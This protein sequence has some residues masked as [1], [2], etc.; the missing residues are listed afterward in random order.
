M[1]IVEARRIITGGVDTHLEFHVAAALDP[2]G[3]LLGTQNFRANALGYAALLDWLSDFG[4]VTKVGVEGTGSYGAGLARFLSRHDIA[5]IEVNR[6]DRADQRRSGK[7]D[8]LDA[9]AAARAA[10]SGKAKAISKGKDGHVEA[11]RVL[12][13]AK[14]SAR[15][16]RAKAI[17]Q[18]RNLGITA[19]DELN[20][21][22]QG[23]TVI[24][25]V[26]EGT[27]LRPKRSSDVVTGATKSALSS[28]AHRI[29][30]LD[31][32]L[33]EL[34]AQIAS[35]VTAVAPDLLARFG[36]GPDT[37]AALLVA[38]GDNPERLHSEAAW[39][40]LC[41]VAPIAASSGKSSG[42]VRLDNGGDRQA[43][44][45]LWRIVLVRIAHDPRTTAYFERR[46][47]EGLTKRDAI[48]I[49]KR[50]VARE[51]YR[52]LPRG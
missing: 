32:E 22:L 30:G 21:R 12:L 9:I 10:L 40:H 27:R 24:G 50:Y 13:V 8:P 18:M 46:V 11:I 31:E 38:A 15:Q 41:G 52:Y 35:Y 43:N 7:S 5:V 47:K 3:A 45:A 28:L 19:P 51:L 33:A 49:L 1:T 14:R 2:V 39:A 29:V 36:V 17:I 48:R 42:H 37:A 23:L 16:A 20:R 6:P 44:S 26:A 4:E 34:N 25:L